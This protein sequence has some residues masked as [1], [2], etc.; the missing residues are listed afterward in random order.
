MSILMFVVG[1]L[2]AFGGLFALVGGLIGGGRS[3]MF[4]PMGA[5]VGLI[6][7]ALALLYFVPAIH[8]SRY[9]SRI[10]QLRAAGLVGDLESALDA[11]KSFWKF[12]GI[13]TAIVVSVYAVVLLFVLATAF[14]R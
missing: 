14:M 4:G 12:I 1:G 6:Y 7:V 9:A 3:G 2:M 11:Q 13:F 5:F 8:L 10:A